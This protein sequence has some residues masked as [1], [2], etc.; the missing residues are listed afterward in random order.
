MVFL[1]KTTNTMLIEVRQDILDK[2]ISKDAPVNSEAIAFLCE[3]ALAA[4]RGKH[5]VYVPSL[6]GNS[7]LASALKGI[8]G[9][10][11][12]ALL[13][14]SQ[15]DKSRFH[16]IIEKLNTK[17][18]CSFLPVGEEEGWK[19][20]IHINPQEMTDFEVSSET[21]VLGENLNDVIFFDVL[22]DYF[23]A[24]NRQKN[25]NRCY[26]SLMGGGDTTNIVYENE[27]KHQNHF[28]L[29]ITDSDFIVPSEEGKEIESLEEDS[30]AKKVLDVHLQY[31]PNVAFFYP[32]RK[33]SEVENLI[34]KAIYQE[35]GTNAKQNTVLNH[36]YSFYDMK[37]GLSYN[38]LWFQKQY[39][40]WK[41]VYQD[42]V[43]FTQL[44]SIRNQYTTYEDYKAAINGKKLLPGWSN[45]ILKK[46]MDNPILVGKLRKIKQ[47]DLSASQNF[48]WSRI[49]EL[50][51]NWTCS[52]KPR[53]A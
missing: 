27:C 35:N 21:H 8:V 42:D 37:K 25:V 3:L 18:V 15:N 12:V 44:D 28:C 31:N 51:Y 45:D 24:L 49:G 32:M 40:Y 29:V 17:A 53:R 22:F 19:T 26:Y 38:R 2:A 13:R 1:T 41:E 52:L 11:I 10:N 47:S 9:N 7:D 43:D 16:A 6:N 20:V 34:P 46:I 33:V 5:I 14:S 39:D 4:K 30:T 48:E 36:D 23:A 50:M